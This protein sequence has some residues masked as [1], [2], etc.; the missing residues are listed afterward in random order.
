MVLVDILVDSTYI[1]C[2]LYSHTIAVTFLALARPGNGT[3]CQDEALTI[4]IIIIIMNIMKIMIMTMIIIIII[5]TR[6]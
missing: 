5:M 2:L 4:M 1:I 6:R 3:L